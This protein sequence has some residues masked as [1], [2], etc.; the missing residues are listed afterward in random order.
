LKHFGKLEEYSG[1][2][3]FKG[4]FIEYQNSIDK[5]NIVLKKNIELDCLSQE[6]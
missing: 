6:L 1:K 4:L 5:K 2:L 3:K